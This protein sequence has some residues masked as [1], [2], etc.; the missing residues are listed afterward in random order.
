[1]QG[2]KENEKLA[3]MP[4]VLVSVLAAAGGGRCP[5]RPPT[6]ATCASAALAATGNLTTALTFFSIK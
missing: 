5:H 1:M 3:L 6:A 4:A 2:K